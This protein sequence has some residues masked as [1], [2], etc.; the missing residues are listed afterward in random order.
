MTPIQIA[1]ICHEAN[2]AYCK[3]IGDGSQKSWAE[4]E[5]WQ[6]DSAVKGVEFA[7]S[8]PDAKPSHQHDAWLEDKRRDGWTYGA[9]KDPAAKTH[10]CFVL[11]EALPD[12]QKAKDYLFKA[13]VESLR[14]FVK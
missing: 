7:L 10:P 9:V 6:R 5:K 4:A 2:R 3:T 14:E 1:E 13:V 11:Y 12:E 8:N